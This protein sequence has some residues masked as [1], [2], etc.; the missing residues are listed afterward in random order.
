MKENDTES[1]IWCAYFLGKVLLFSVHETI[2]FCKQA[3]VFTSNICS[4][5]KIFFLPEVRSN[6]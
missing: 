4:R 5:K 6:I 1:L 2:K 3:S